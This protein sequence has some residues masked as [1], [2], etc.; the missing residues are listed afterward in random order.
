M[1]HSVLGWSWDCLCSDPFLDLPQHHFVSQK[2]LTPLGCIPLAPVST[3]FWLVEDWGGGKKREARAFCPP[4]HLQGYSPVAAASP[5]RSYFFRCSQ[6]LGSC[7]IPSFFH[8]F[9]LGVTVA[10]RYCCSLAYLPLPCLALSSSSHLYDQF[11]KL[12]S[13]L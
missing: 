10:S 4:F 9:I 13:L 7:S 3:D 1:E 5:L 6:Q 2:E 11:P 12:I 8:L